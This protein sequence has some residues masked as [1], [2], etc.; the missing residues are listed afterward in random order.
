MNRSLLLKVSVFS[1]LVLSISLSGCKLPWDKDDDDSG[2]GAVAMQ[3]CSNCNGSG[4]LLVPYYSYDPFTGISTIAGYTQKK[5][6]VCNGTGLVP[7]S[8]SL[9]N[10]AQSS[11]FCLRGREK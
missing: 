2:G 4:Y 10:Q 3:E 7:V 6:P 8:S 9:C 5:C 11:H 1:L